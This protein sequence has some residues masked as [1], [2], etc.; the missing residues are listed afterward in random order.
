MTTLAS[1]PLD[2]A[3]PPGFRVALD[4]R[5]RVRDGGAVL[6]GGAPPRLVRL[7]PAARRLLRARTFTVTDTTTAALA[8]R[9]LD[10][11]IVHPV[12]AEPASRPDGIRNSRPPDAQL[13]VTVVVPV[14]DRTDGLRRLLAALPSGFGGEADRA[15][16]GGEADRAGLGGEVVV[17]DDGSA[18]PAAVRAVAEAAGARVLRHDIPRGPAAARNAG[19][20]LARTPLVAFLDS[21]VVPAPGWLEIL[22]A[23]FADPAVALAAPRIVALPPVDGVLGRYEAVR[24]SLDLGLDPALIVPRTRVAYVPSAALVVRREALGAGF[25]ERLHVAEDVDLVLRLYAAGWRLRYDP[26]ARVAHDHRTSPR[27]WWLRKAFYGTGAAPLARRHVGSVPPMVLTPWAAAVAAL[28]LTGRLKGLAVAVAIGAVATE[29]L[30]RSL[31]APPLRD[32]GRRAAREVAASSRGLAS[33]RG[34]APLARPRATA[35]FL[36]ALGAA[37]AVGQTVDAVNRH[38]WPLSALACLASR[39][40]RR[41]VAVIALAEGVVDWWRADPGNRPP[42]PAHVLARRLD[43]LAYG[44]GLWWG[45]VRHRTVAPLVPG[46]PGTA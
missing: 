22:G 39:R 18:D 23:H 43:D 44:A 17:V 24:S 10:G 19:A 27:A 25:D 32:I 11:G 30:A 4:R 8:R 14:K 37:G 28:L 36:V 40:A 21:D 15:G 41:T 31:G 16:F 6:I 3:L 1:P 9:L 7:A 29:R 46:R 42:L 33:S 35:A 5:V 45:A 38:Y 26:A 20:A 34:P 13:A 2:L 12:L